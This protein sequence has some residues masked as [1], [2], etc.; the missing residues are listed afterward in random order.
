MGS[1]IGAPG[2][3]FSKFSGITFGDEIV[4]RKCMTNEETM[5]SIRGF[6]DRLS[7][8]EVASKEYICTRCNN[9][10]VSL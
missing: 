10:I 9:P 6:T 1:H 8:D 5:N 4:C 7:D 2:G 3:D